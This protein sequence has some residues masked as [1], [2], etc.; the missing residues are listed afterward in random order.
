MTWFICT[1]TENDHSKTNIWTT[2]LCKGLPTVNTFYLTLYYSLWMT[3]WCV[4][5]Q[6]RLMNVMVTNW[7][8]PH[9]FCSATFRWC[10]HFLSVEAPPVSLRQSPLDF[11]FHS[12]TLCLFLV[13]SALAN[14]SALY[15]QPYC[16]TRVNVTELILLYSIRKTGREEDEKRVFKSHTGKGKVATEYQHRSW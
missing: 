10:L 8:V 13:F 2:L 1:D 12:A 14:C 3:L 16:N 6:V 15:R 5:L 4:R 7:R 9:S 11:G